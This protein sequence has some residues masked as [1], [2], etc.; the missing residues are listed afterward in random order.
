MVADTRTNSRTDGVYIVSL[1]NGKKRR[2]LFCCSEGEFDEHC[3]NKMAAVKCREGIACSTRHLS[4]SSVKNAC[5]TRHLSD[6]SVK[7]NSMF[8]A[9][10]VGQFWWTRSLADYSMNRTEQNRTEQNSLF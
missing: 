6:N 4:D 2:L 8:D 3:G 7:T 5:S 10:P 1:W 9:T